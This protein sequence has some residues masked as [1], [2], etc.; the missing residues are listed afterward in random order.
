VLLSTDSLKFSKW[1]IDRA[2]GEVSYVLWAI[3]LPGCQCQR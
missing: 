2:N 3:F 1:Y